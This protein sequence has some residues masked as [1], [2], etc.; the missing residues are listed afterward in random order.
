MKD[1]WHASA[2]IHPSSFILHH[3]TL[4]TIMR[5]TMPVRRFAPLLENATI[6]AIFAAAVAVI[7]PLGNFPLNDDGYYA[8]PAFDFAHTGVFHLTVAPA[9]VRAQ[10][11]WGALWVRLFGESYDVLRASTLVLAALTVVIVNRTLARTSLP[12]PL[13][14]LASLALA[15][16]PIFFWSACTFMTEVP[17]VFASAAALYCYFRALD[18]ERASWLVAGGVAAAISWWVRQTGIL[19]VLPPLILLLA[20]RH[21]LSRRW[22]RDASIATVPIVVFGA[23]FLLRRDWLMGSPGEFQGLYKFW[24]EETFRLP[25]Q[26]GLVYHYFLYTL[27]IS[28]LAFLPLAVGVCFA[29]RFARTRLNLIGLGAATAAA[30]YG[31]YELVSNGLPFP[32]YAKRSCCDLLP[33]NIFM[34][35]GVGPPT[36]P[37]VWSGDIEYPFHLGYNARVGLTYASGLLVA[38]LV[39]RM[40][41]VV[42]QRLPRP[43]E[44]ALLLV[45]LTHFLV[46]TAGLCANSQYFDRYAVDSAWSLVLVLP[47]LIPWERM[48]AR[49]AVVIAL[50]CVMTF[51][52]LGIQEYFAWNRA[53]WQA[54]WYLRNSGAAM[55]SID[56]GSEPFNIFEM[57]W[58]KDM[59][60]RRRMAFGPGRRRYVLGFHAMPDCRVLA[61]FPYEGWLGTHQGEIVAQE[62]IR[63]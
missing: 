27:Q 6:L 17:F 39:W 47:L 20:Y 37:D 35:F 8:L 18:E 55:T 52:I 60:T 51:S 61:R 33:G 32:Y 10:V 34:N 56:G 24:G 49:I 2:L 16:H 36:L 38:V 7:R 28:A 11:L 13:R 54:Y 14:F 5:G 1:E 42:W 21:R 22:R 23:I 31:M 58:V 26:I 57:A 53:R 3:L 45:A 63:P 62:R 50:C 9:S 59:H 44:N 48:G 40:A 12:A 4:R 46:N 30:S 41:A 29:L 15:F 19:N 25:Q 43:R